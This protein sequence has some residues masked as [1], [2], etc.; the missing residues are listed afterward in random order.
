[1]NRTFIQTETFTKKWDDLGLNDDDLRSLEQYL[2]NNPKTGAELIHGSGIRKI[3]IP[4][5]GHGKRGGAR[6]IYIDIEI[7]ESIYLLDV[8]AKNEKENLTQNEI[9]ILSKLAKKL[10]GDD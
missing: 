9:S 3:R 5:N 7:K 2:L 8:Y 6:V 10:K 4:I 1:M